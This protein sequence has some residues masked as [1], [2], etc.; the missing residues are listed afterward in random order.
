MLVLSSCTKSQEEIIDNNSNQVDD[1][2]GE[3]TEDIDEIVE[4]INSMTLDEKIGQLLIIGFN[5]TSIDER[6]ET[7]IKK[8][9]IG[10]FI[11]FRENISSVEQTTELLNTLKDTNKTNPIPLFLSIDEEG[12]RVRRLPYPFLKL[13]TAKKIGD[14]NDKNISFQYGKILGRR[15]K[16]IGFNMNFAPV[17]DVNSNPQN[18]VIGDRAFGATV[19]IV[20]NTGIQVMNGINSENIIPIIKHFPGHGDTSADSHINIPI[21]DKGLTQ[22]EHLELIPFTRGIEAG[23]DGVMIGHIM[24]PQIDDTYPATLSKR[25][26]TDILREKLFFDGVVISDD[27]TMGA[28]AK[29]YEI[30]DAAVSYLKAGGDILLI[31]HGHDEPIKVIQRIKE[32]VERGN[33]T[34]E[35]LDEKLYRILKLK[36][37]YN[38]SDEIVDSEDIQSINHDTQLLLDKIKEF[39]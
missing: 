34:E 13:P 4:L 20:S 19:D 6:V 11:L 27:M 33:I 36:D 23:V 30:E 3:E 38:I 2:L 26:I 10:G 12:G 25:I 8:Y 37:K 28:I 7:M 15:I 39:K 17:M 31:C 32:E 9:H 24:F 14:I 18:P 21:V 35:A 29:N 22:I 16:S 1:E 5:G